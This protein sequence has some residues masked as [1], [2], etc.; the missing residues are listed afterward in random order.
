[1]AFVMLALLGSGCDSGHSSGVTL[2]TAPGGKPLAG[3]H[4]SVSCSEPVLAQRLTAQAAAWSGK[5]GAT[6]KFVTGASEPK[7]GEKQA[8]V[9]VVSASEFGK[10]APD[11]RS[12]PA[13]LKTNDHPLQRSRIAEVYRDTLTNWGGDVQG[14]TLKSNGFLMIYRADR[15]A[16]PATRAAFQQQ[17]GRSL[18]PP[19]TYEDIRDIAAFFHARDGKP[20][21]TA[22]PPSSPMLLWQFQQLA[23]CYDRKAIG[24]LDASRLGNKNPN[25][26][27]SFQLDANSGDPRLTQP[28]FLAAAEWLAATQ[29]Y[30]PKPDST[31]DP[32]AAIESGTAV[33]G[34]YSL[35]D[36]A[37]LALDPNTGAIPTK[38]AISPLPGTRS[39]Y[40]AEGK[41]QVASGEGNYVPFLGSDTYISGVSKT[42]ENPDAAWEFLTELGNMTGSLASLSD[43]KLGS[44]PFRREHV[45]ETRDAIWHSYKFD[46]ASSQK[47]ADAMRK[48]LALNIVNPVTVLRWPDQGER[49]TTLETE[50]RTLLAQ[51]TIAKTA[52]ERVSTAWKALDAKLPAATRDQHRRNALGIP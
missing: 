26:F 36:V 9:V 44:G 41:A 46:Q 18:N 12:M 15:F 19:R 32:V 31:E 6:V 35:R 48:G 29:L 25:S 7:P 40:D 34:I 28:A 8:D 43:P 4:L 13:S 39:Y 49:M 5:S 30:R 51:P 11:L 47:L 27:L 38:L 14:I 45:D 52:M 17:T 20:S 16:D 3:V 23:A 37:R 22:F 1:M 21:L 33:V 50:L 2:P 42:C 10:V 24:E